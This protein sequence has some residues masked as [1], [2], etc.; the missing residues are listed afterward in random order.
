ML[1][2]LTPNRKTAAVLGCDG[3]G[4]SDGLPN[5]QPP[6]KDQTHGHIR[7]PAARRNLF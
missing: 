5:V 6:G 2:F 1:P 7:F 4:F 3:L